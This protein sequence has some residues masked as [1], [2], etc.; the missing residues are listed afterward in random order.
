MTVVSNT[1]PLRYLIVINQANLVQQIFGQILIPRG[2]EQELVHPSA[3]EAIRQWMSQKPAWLEIRD[4]TQ[5]PDPELAQRLD[6]GEA[7]AIRLA[8]DLH[9]D[10]LLID[11]FRGRQI[12]TARSITVIGTLGILLESYRQGRVQN[13][14]EVL[15]ELQGERFRVSRRLVREFEEQIRLINPL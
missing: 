10:F 11:E 8:L 14:L 13:P 15:S 6:Q 3:P 4:L 5:P 9:A 1:S 12:A 7:E 2:V